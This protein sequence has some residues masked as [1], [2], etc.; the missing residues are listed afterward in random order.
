VISAKAIEHDFYHDYRPLTI[1]LGYCH[2]WDNRKLTDGEEIITI[3]VIE[4][5]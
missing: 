5:R 1:S 4:T 3:L 2:K